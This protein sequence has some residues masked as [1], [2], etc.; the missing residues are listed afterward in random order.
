MTIGTLVYSNECPEVK[1]RGNRIRLS[2]AVIN[3]I[4]NAYHAVDKEKGKLSLKVQRRGEWILISVL[5]NGT[6]IKAEMMEHIWE[7]GYSGRQ[8]TGLGLAF[9][10]QVVE[11]HGGTI[12]IE[13][14]EGEYTKAVIFLKEERNDNGKHKNDSGH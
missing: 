5:D 6:G 9:T 11:N 1:I 3:L 2:R 12:E 7:L 10:K 8:S 14:M 4:N 13:S